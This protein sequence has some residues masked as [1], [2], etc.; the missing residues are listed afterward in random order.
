M[1]LVNKGEEFADLVEWTGDGWKLIDGYQDIANQLQQQLTQDTIDYVDQVRQSNSLVEPQAENISDMSSTLSETKDIV[2]DIVNVY[3]GNSSVKE[4]SDDINKI[5]ED[6]RNGAYTLDDYNSKMKELTEN[7]DFSLI[8]SSQEQVSQMNEEQINQMYAQQ[9][10]WNALYADASNSLVA[11]TDQFN[12]GKITEEDYA[13]AL[14]GIN[15]RFLELAL[16]AGIIKETE[17]GFVDANGKTVGTY[18]QIK[19]STTISD[20]SSKAFTFMIKKS[21]LKKKKID[22]RNAEISVAGKYIYSYY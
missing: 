19:K 6:F 18:K 14:A 16:K 15:D 21:A 22:L 9:E 20:G 10:M 13:V 5:Q 3:K 1:S 11:I 8:L 12:N 17:N 2:S 4:F 7:T